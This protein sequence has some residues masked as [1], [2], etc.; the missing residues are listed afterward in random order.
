M[1]KSVIAPDGS[2]V[3]LFDIANHLRQDKDVKESLITA[4]DSDKIQHPRVVAHL[5]LEDGAQMDYKLL[6]RL[7][8]SLATILPEGFEVKGYKQQ[9]EFRMSFICKTDSSYYGTEHD[10]YLKPADG[11]L[12][13][14]SF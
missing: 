2:P 11:K 14:V 3:Y 12:E 5:V 10:G 13:T 8:D 6:K 4:I 1:G 7:D 9:Q